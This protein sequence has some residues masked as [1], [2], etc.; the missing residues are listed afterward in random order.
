MK[1]TDMLRDIPSTE[2]RMEQV[3][4]IGFR[5]TDLAHASLVLVHLA[6]LAAQKGEPEVADIMNGAYSI[7]F[8]VAVDG[9]LGGR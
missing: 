9:G 1:V 6:A 2:L 8:Q 3:R 5:S 7:I 4:R